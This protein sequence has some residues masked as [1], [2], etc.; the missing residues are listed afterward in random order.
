MKNPRLS[1]SVLF[2]V[3][4]FFLQSCNS[5][6][7]K[8]GYVESD[9][10]LVEFNETKG[11]A[12][13]VEESTKELRLRFDTLK[14]EFEQLQN[15]FTE[16]LNSYTQEERD[17]TEQLLSKKQS[18]LNKYYQLLTNKIQEE[19]QKVTKELLKKIDK[20][21]KAY[22]KKHD[23]E[24]IFGATSNGNIVYAKKTI[25]LTDEIIQELNK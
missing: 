3:C 20:V 25:N 21:V 17:K 14:F 24:I 5:N 13:E 7:T 9:R 16:K 18:D 19:D 12:I 22:G 6:S 10:L 15:T 2:V 1:F 4:L 8:L 23:Y 11:A